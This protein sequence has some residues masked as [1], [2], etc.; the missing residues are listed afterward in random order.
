MYNSA[1]PIRKKAKTTSKKVPSASKMKVKKNNKIIKEENIVTPS[2]QSKSTINNPRIYIPIILIVLAILIY[3]FR[4]WFIVAIVNGQPISRTAFVHEL[5]A[6]NGKQILN[7]LVVRTLV[8]Q[9]A[10]KKHISISQKEIDDALK[11]INDQL[12]QQGQTLDGA[13][14]ARGMTKADFEDQIKMQKLIEKMLGNQVAVS[15]QEVND[16]IDKNKDTFPPSLTGDELKKQV[17]QQL[18]QQKLSDKAGL[19]L[20]DLQKKAKITYFASF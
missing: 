16:Y 1:M 6:R 9:E 5:E 8:F 17:K 12:S 7:E 19:W 3:V 2:V 10:N 4:S 20:Q 15:D 11:G 18:Q 14:A 13:L